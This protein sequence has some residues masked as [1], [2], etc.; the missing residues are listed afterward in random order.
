MVKTLL[1]DYLIPL[2]LQTHEK[3]FEV[4]GADS[5]LSD[6]NLHQ[7]TKKNDEKHYILKGLSSRS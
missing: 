2:N 1:N 7:K 4:K 5:Y 6:L 3:G